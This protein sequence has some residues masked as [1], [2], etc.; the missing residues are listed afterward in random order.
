METLW[1]EH[2]DDEGI[3]NEGQNNRPSRN[4]TRYGQHLG[5]LLRRSSHFSEMSDG[6]AVNCTFPSQGAETWR[7]ST[8]EVYLNTHVQHIM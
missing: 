5:S 2:D 1:D 8:V 7:E 3:K 4:M 6:K